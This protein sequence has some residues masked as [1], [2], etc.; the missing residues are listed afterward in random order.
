[1]VPG[2]ISKKNYKVVPTSPS[3]LGGTVLE[4]F[5]DSEEEV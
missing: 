4:F 2:D 5:T 1:M 3:E